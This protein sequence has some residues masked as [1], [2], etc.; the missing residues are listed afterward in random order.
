MKPFFSIVLPIYNQEE[1]VEK[2]L[3]NYPLALNSLK[4]SWELIL[5]VNGSKDNSYEKAIELT[6]KNDNIIVYNLKVGGWGR[7]VIF[8]LSKANGELIC[9]TN[10]ART[11]V[12][13]L[14]TILK[15]AKANNTYLIK[16]SRVVRES[17]LRKLGSILYNLEFRF[18]FKTPVWDV[19]GTP[20]VIPKK[21]YQKI[22]LISKN[23]LID[24]ELIARCFKLG[25][26]IIEVPVEVTTR[27]S[28]K[29]TT[30]FKSAFNMYSGLLKLSKKVHG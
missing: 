14:I 3:K 18:L 12:A 30:D 10:S 20:K 13:D 15:T 24:A 28:G 5:V 27:I 11:N 16:A 29:S 19:N 4:E 25:F 26:K 17:L 22:K 23:D 2:I 7:A 21:V 9:Y 1:H 8:G 6:K